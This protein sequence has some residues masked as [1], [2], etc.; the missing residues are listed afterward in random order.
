MKIIDL[1]CL[2]IINPQSSINTFQLGAPV[3]HTVTGNNKRWKGREFEHAQIL[4]QNEGIDNVWASLSII[5]NLFLNVG[6]FELGY[7]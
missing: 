5:L 1:K 3:I 6:R 7:S 2:I 4:N